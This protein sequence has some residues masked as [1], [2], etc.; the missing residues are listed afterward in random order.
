MNAVALPFVAS[1]DLFA[2]AHEVDG[3]ITLRLW[4]TADLCV[5]EPLAETL[6]A[7]HRAALRLG[8]KRIAVDITAL[9]FMNSSCV[10]CFVSWL[11]GVQ[12]GRDTIPYSVHFISNPAMHWQRTSL[13]AIRCMVPDI[14][15]VENVQVG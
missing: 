2:A 5:V 8:T 1:A 7:V 13:R 15:T 6:S 10:K 3:Q 9:E 14:V 11:A 12:S 4:G